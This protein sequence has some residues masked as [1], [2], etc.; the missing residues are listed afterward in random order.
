VD[1]LAIAAVLDGCF[2]SKQEMAATPVAQHG[3]SQQYAR[4]CC[5]TCRSSTP[6]AAAETVQRAGCR[7]DGD[8][9]EI[10]GKDAIGQE[11]GS[12]VVV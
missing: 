1:T 5:T 9:Q 6:H 12:S 8:V 3:C 2:S 11:D 7:W 10:I 4:T